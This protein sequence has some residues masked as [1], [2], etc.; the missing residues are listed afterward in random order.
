MAGDSIPPPAKAAIKQKIIRQAGVRKQHHRIGRMLIP[1]IIPLFEDS[2]IISLSDGVPKLVERLKLIS[3]TPDLPSLSLDSTSGIMGSP[4]KTLQRRTSLHDT[5][6]Q[7][8]GTEEITGLFGDLVE[9]P[10]DI[11]SFPSPWPI[12]DSKSKQR[13]EQLKSAHAIHS[14]AIDSLMAN[15][16]GIE[17]VKSDLLDIVFRIAVVASSQRVSLKSEELSVVFTG[18]PGTGKTTV[19]E[20][21]IEYLRECG[22]CSQSPPAPMHL[23]GSAGTVM[24]YGEEMDYPGYESPRWESRYQKYLIF[25]D[26]IEERAKECGEKLFAWIRGFN[27]T[28]ILVITGS[29]EAT[30]NFFVSACLT[31]NTFSRI[32]FLNLTEGELFQLFIRELF[33]KCGNNFRIKGTR[34]NGLPTRV[35]IR[36]IS[37]GQVTGNS[38]NFKLIGPVIDEIFLRQSK[39]LF[40][41]AMASQEVDHF[42]LTQEDLIGPPPSK[43]LEAFKPWQK[44]Q[45]MIGLKSV[46]ASLEA[47]VFRLQQ[48]YQRELEELPPIK[49]SLNRLFLGNP[50]TGKTTVAKLYAQVLAQAG[51]LSSSE[52]MIRTPADFIGIY[53]GHSEEKTKDILDASK[54]KVLI[55]DEAYMLGSG[56]R[57]KPD[58]FRMAVVDTIVGEIQSS[59]NKDRC[60]LLL[61]Y[62]RE[63]EEMFRKTNPGLARRF[64]LSSAFEFEDYTKEELCEILELKLAE[65]GLEVTDKAKEVAMD[66]IERA[67]NC[68]V[69]SNAGEVDILLAR[70]KERQH[71][72]LMCAGHSDAKSMR[73]LEAC[74]IDEDF[75]RIDRTATDVKE[76][77]RSMVGCEALVAR[78]ENWQKIVKNSKA[79]DYGNPR[80][81]IPFNFLFRGPPGTGKTT[82]ARK[83]GKVFYDLGFLATTEVVECSASDLIAEYIG[84]TG[85]K[86]RRVFEKAIGKVLF[87]DEAYRLTSTRHSYTSE[88][89]GEIVDILTQE[90]FHNR[91]VVILAGYEKDINELMQSNPGLSSRFPEYINFDNL[92]P[93]QCTE[94]LFKTITS[95]SVTIGDWPASEID[96]YFRELA[97]L[98]FW[99]NARDVQTAAK[100][101]ISNMLQQDQ[102]SDCLE[103]SM[104]IDVLAEMLWERGT[105]APSR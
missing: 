41:E 92:T 43:A 104:V 66:I 67:R 29:E 93:A 83:M 3:S 11:G 4:Q 101:I 69:F 6:T 64:P 17:K 65:Q 77:F 59:D 31:N 84:Q 49:S 82:T 86:T 38:S 76:L 78:L 50:G 96:F 91:L 90:R 48:N 10:A 18:N 94:L 56:H 79:L 63:M 16:W 80:D 60:V 88:A 58:P 46:K 24:S 102:P 47:L 44:L 42:L 57:D 40:K 98:P 19:S 22:I 97:L 14:P 53:W 15:M 26:N 62:R 54:G 21:Y 20:Y 87:I 100:N 103:Y 95:K 73:T 39:R 7:H 25:V 1:P 35:L 45:S 85:P 52:V 55:I 71:R 81:F 27:R 30:N 105:R 68:M 34:I 12:D 33:K 74:D 89:V 13:W 72:R 2:D 5:D 37:S 70:A 9:N 8:V 32:Y 23:G 36:R 28:P 75:E 61:G 51:L 99:G